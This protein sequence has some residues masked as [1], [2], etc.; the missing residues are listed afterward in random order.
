MNYPWVRANER[1]YAQCL[2]QGLEKVSALQIL[3]S[4]LSLTPLEGT[5]QLL[6]LISVFCWV[7]QKQTLR[8]G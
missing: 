6:N 4:F 2:V 1:M 8:G 5:G 3:A 7:V